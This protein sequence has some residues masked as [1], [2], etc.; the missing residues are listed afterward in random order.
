MALGA[1]LWCAAAFAE[2]PEHA[3]IVLGRQVS[4]GAGAFGA[5]Y[6]FP[7]GRWGDLFTTQ[8][9][10]AR[11]LFGGLTLEGGVLNAV[12]IGAVSNLHSVTGT[13]RAGWTFERLSLTA[14]VS[15]QYAPAAQPTTQLLPTLKATYAFEPFA[16]TGA[17]FD[18][19]ALQLGRVSVDVG[20]WGIGY[21]A[22]LG[23][24]VHAR[25]DVSRGFGIGV[26]A[27]AVKAA[28]A[29]FAFVAV[30]G[31]WDPGAGG[32]AP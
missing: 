10:E 27:F 26:Q 30:N 2:R 28:A 29:Q 3:H 9:L 19:H 15:A 7:G 11:W 14:G 1:F 12:P 20:N 21:V 8:Q 5:S 13:V 6:A 24:E 31:T 16:L 32:G 17:L 18:V 22:P 4:L 23:A 25:F